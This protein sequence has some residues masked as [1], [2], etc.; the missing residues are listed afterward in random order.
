M[1]TKNNF[2][3]AGSLKKIKVSFPK[4]KQMRSQNALKNLLEAAEKIVLEGDI[5]NFNA[6]NLSE[7]SGYSLGALVQ[8][9][10]KVENIFLH[11]IAH[12][13]TKQF[14]QIAEEFEAFP[15]SGT[16][17]DFSKMLIDISFRRIRFVSTSVMRYYEGRALG[18]TNTVQDV[19]AYT[20]ECIPLLT[21]L[22]Q[23][24]KSNTFREM[25]LFEMKYLLRAMF[26]F[27][28]RPLIEGHEDAGTEKHRD[29][30]VTH[31]SNLLSKTDCILSANGIKPTK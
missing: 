8:R 15:D 28:E 22:I 9:L 27:V 26:L 31:I 20:D 12:Q 4:A 24:N 11:A 2:S 21:K 19:H 23:K 14:N 29:M 6:R 10:G 7:V 1:G 18:R 25:S 17:T 3:V 5:G 13:R 16:T 30:A